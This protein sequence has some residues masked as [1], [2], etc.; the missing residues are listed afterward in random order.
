MAALVHCSKDD[1]GDDDEEDDQHQD[2]SSRNIFRVSRSISDR[3]GFVNL[4]TSC[5]KTCAVS[6]SIV[7]LP[8]RSSRTSYDLIRRRSR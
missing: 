5:K 6:E 4:Y 7:Y 2:R 1:G 8:A 3:F